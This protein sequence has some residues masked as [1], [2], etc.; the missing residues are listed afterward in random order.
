MINIDDLEK[1]SWE[2]VHFCESKNSLENLEKLEKTGI[3]FFKIEGSLINDADDLFR[4]ISE[5]MSFPDYFGMNW[6]AL[7]DCLKDMEWLEA[8][9][10]VLIIN[11]SEN[12]WKKCYGIC[13]MLAMIWQFCAEEWSKENVPF[14]LIFYK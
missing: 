2:C 14:H 11:D 9:G 5:T 13:G 12:L 1:S 3:K 4:K 10:Y 7:T 8:K 6:D